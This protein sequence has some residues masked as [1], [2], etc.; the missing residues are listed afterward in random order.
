MKVLVVAQQLRELIAQRTD[1]LR[2]LDTAGVDITVLADPRLAAEVPDFYASRLV[3]W[4]VDNRRLRPDHVLRQ[5][6]AVAN[7]TRSLGCDV[8]HSVHYRAAV[9]AGLA[10]RRTGVPLVAEFGGTGGVSLA[11]VRAVARRALGGERVI[12][13]GQS[14][15][16]IEELRYCKIREWRLVPG[17]G[18][19]MT[20]RTAVEPAVSAKVLFIGRML[21]SKGARHFVELARLAQRD[22][23][24][25]HLR[26]VMIGSC[27]G[28]ESDRLSWREVLAAVQELP[29]L[30]YR[31]AVLPEVVHDE[32]SGALVLLLP[33]SYPEGIPRAAIEA[34]ASGLPVLSSKAGGMGSVDLDLGIANDWP[35]LRLG[36]LDPGAWLG[37]LRVVAAMPQAERLAL[38]RSARTLATEHF[39]ASHHAGVVLDAYRQLVV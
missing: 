7:L 26:F 3:E 33:S 13:I 1:L 28:D 4:R 11:V 27:D 38:A 31:G 23:S 32:M 20:E 9:I 5:V 15:T 16:N 19:E 21:I 30:E 29:N 12:G 17:A 2:R 10:Q 25:T 22:S 37:A 8:V 24:L 39:S 35:W 14:S 34:L 6:Q 36:A 18:V